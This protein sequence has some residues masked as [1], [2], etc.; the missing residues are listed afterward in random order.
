[1]VLENCHN[2]D[3]QDPCPEAKAC[4]AT[5]VCPYNLWRLGRDIGASWGSIY[6]NLQ[7]VI[8][9]N[10]GTPSLSRP[11]RWGYPDMMQVGQLASYEEDRAHF[12]PQ[13]SL[14]SVISRWLATVSLTQPVGCPCRRL[15]GCELSADARVRSHGRQHHGAHLAHH[16]QP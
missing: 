9:W 8:P 16:L 4:P 11:G 14:P 1:M 3:G 7:D 10:E 13:H 12:G 5:G 2:S 15:G 6:S